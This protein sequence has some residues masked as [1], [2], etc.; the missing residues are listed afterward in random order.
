[1]CDIAECFV[2]T[3]RKARKSHKC[4][5]CG[6]AIVPK[7]RYWVTSGIFDGDPFRRKTCQDCQEVIEYLLACPGFDCLEE[8]LF[9]EL[10]N[11][12]LTTF[13]DELEKEVALVPWLQ[14]KGDRWKLT[15]YA[16]ALQTAQNTYKD[17]KDLPL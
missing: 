3:L 5:E 10:R 9:T 2:H 7:E 13:D 16:S 12:D 4:I 14:E 6:S 8:D 11:C 17:F 15:K 1:M